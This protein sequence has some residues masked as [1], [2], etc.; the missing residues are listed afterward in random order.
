MSSKILITGSSGFLG[1][2]ICE[3]LSNTENITT[4]LDIKPPVKTFNNI[5][6]ETLSINEYLK[7]N[8]DSLNDFDLI[9]HAASVLPYKGNKDNLIE[10]NIKT[11]LNLIEK[12]SNLKNTFF[13]YISSSGVYGK[14]YDIPVN[15]TTQFNPLDLYAETKIE[16]E[17]NIHKN[18]KK[19]SFS[20]IRPRTILGSNRGGIFEIFFKLIKYNIPIPLPNNGKQKIQFVDVDDLARLVVYVGLNRINGKWPA[21]A[22]HPKSLKEHLNVLGSKLNKRILT[23]NINPNFFR[24]VGSLLVNLKISNFT[25]W[26]FESFPLD[27]YFE[28]DWKPSGFEYIFSCEDTFLKSADTFLKK[29]K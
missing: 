26:H 14:P 9:I 20:I 8:Q 17:K 27:F 22:P 12:I 28:K 15:S 6:Y 7:N 24:L 1:L 29:A 21:G 16:S 4:A 10:T 5:E 2:K 18:L 11:T 25:K 19:E 13:V 23:I 3:I